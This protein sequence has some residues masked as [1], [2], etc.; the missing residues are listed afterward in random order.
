MVGL[1]GAPHHQV[2]R[3][4][5]IGRL[6][7]RLVVGE[8]ETDR[9][10]EVGGQVGGAGPPDDGLVAA[11]RAGDVAEGRAAIASTGSI[12]AGERKSRRSRP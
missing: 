7:R 6:G 11:G 3:L 12:G 5:E 1:N 4:D 9:A 10:G 2:G 8:L